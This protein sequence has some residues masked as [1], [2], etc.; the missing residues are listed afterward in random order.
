MG[1]CFGGWAAFYMGSNTHNTS[2]SRLIDYLVVGRLTWLTR[3]DMD[4]VCVLT[5]VLALKKDPAYTV[6]LKEH[7]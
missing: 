6:K 5:Q 7:P 1:Y 4:N 2:G 3:E